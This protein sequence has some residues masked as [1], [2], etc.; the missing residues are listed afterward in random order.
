MV[1]PAFAAAP[2]SPWL[3]PLAPITQLEELDYFTAT[4]TPLMQY[5]VGGR[6]WFG[7]A[8]T[9]KNLYGFAPASMVSRLT[10]SDMM[11]NSGEIYGRVTSSNGWFLKGYLGL[12]AMSGG[13]LQDEDFPPG[14][15]PYSSTIS[16][17][18]GGYLNYASLD[19]GYN[20]VRGGDFALGAFAGYHLLNE[21]VNAYGCTQT[22]GNPDVCQPTIPKSVEAISQTNTWQSVRVGLNGSVTFAE[23][24]KFTADAAWLP[25]VQLHG[26]DSHLLRI[27]NE[28]GDFTGPVPEKGTGMGYQLEAVLNYQITPRTSIGFG[29]RYWYMQAHGSTEFADHVVGLLAYEQPVKWNTNIFGA[30]VQLSYKFGPYPIN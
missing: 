17:Q 15:S 24:F 30:F 27:G 13:S 12:G 6:Y 14:I 9:S 5:E 28:L 18:R 1:A 7:N 26:T 16:Q 19:V 20:L 21:V 25:Y 3:A 8:K 11:T 29:G 2:V 22:A 10:Y 4:P 23:R